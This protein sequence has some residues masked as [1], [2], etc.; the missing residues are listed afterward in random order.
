LEET[1]LFTRYEL[2]NISFHAGIEA[3]KQYEVTGNGTYTIGGEV[4]IQQDIFLEVMID[5]GVTQT[6]GLCVN[7]SRSVEQAWPALQVV[8]DQTNGTPFQTYHL[9]LSAVPAFQIRS[10]WFDQ[11]SGDV[12]LE[13]EGNTGKV[14]VERSTNVAGPYT[15]LPLTATE[16]SYTDPGV[17]TNGTR[18]FYLLQQ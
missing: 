16:Q 13:W 2:V 1:P 5:D 14:Q 7:Q 10:M 6:K 4:A 9:T 12:R 11:K 18:W 8:A 17:L 3:G 15:P